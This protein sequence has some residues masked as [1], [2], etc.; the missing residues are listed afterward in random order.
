MTIKETNQSEKWDIDAGSDDVVG[1]LNR[2]SKLSYRW[3]NT[4]LKLGGGEA[5]TW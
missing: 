4:G 3:K 2:P 1:I 5:G